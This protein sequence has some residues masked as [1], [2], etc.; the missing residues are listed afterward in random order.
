MD[1]ARERRWLGPRMCGLGIAIAL[2]C[3]A[4][5]G[6]QAQPEKEEGTPVGGLSED[7]SDRPWAQGVSKENQDKARQ[8]FNEGNALLTEQFF[9]RAA[10]KYREALNYWDHPAIHYNL[11][12]ALMNLDQPIE[13][14]ESLGKALAY[15]P[16]PLIDDQKYSLALQTRQVLEG[17]LVRVEVICEQPGAT[18]TMDGKLLFTSPGKQ[19]VVAKAG[20]HTI[21]ATKPG[22]VTDNKQL[23]L[24]AGEKTKVELRLITLEELTYETRRWPGWLPWTVVGAGVAVAV[25]G[26]IFHNTARNNFASFDADFDETCR[27]RGGCEE[28]EVPNLIDRLD[29]A[30][31]QQNLAFSGYIAGGLIA[32]AGFVMV[33]INQ[34]QLVRRESPDAAPEP[35]A[36]GVSILPLVT[37]VSAGISAELRF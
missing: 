2:L 5:T 29:S 8:L 30:A 19:D 1:R 15:G 32:T 12:L 24:N 27:P 7:E 33:Y 23:V 34:P 26:G 22:F 11:S 9:L 6:V 10:T 16:I 14:Y 21:V 17:Q 37:P 18:V 35:N 36:S 13:L 3:G 20:E 4:V 28:G 25:T 31:L